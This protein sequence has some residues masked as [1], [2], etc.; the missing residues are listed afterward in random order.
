MSCRHQLCKS[1]HNLARYCFLSSESADNCR[2]Y[3]CSVHRTLKPL[4]FSYTT[5]EYGGRKPR[6]QRRLSQIVA[7]D[8]RAKHCSYSNRYNLVV[9]SLGI[10]YIDKLDF[11]KLFYKARLTT[12]TSKNIKNIFQT[13]GIISFDPQNVLSRLKVNIPN[14]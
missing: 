10:N 6:L 9:N 14:L 1:F 4:G 5:Q 8:G 3:H 2:S 7:M 12:F 13:A 11:L